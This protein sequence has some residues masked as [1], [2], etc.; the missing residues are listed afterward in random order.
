MLAELDE[1]SLGALRA[2]LIQEELGGPGRGGQGR[3]LPRLGATGKTGSGKSTLGNLL[4]GMSGLLRSTGFQDC[5]D[6]ADVL[7]FP[8]GLSYLDLPGVTGS[9]ALENGNRA[10]LGLPQRA[11]LERV[12]EVRV[13]EFTPAGVAGPPDG[14]LWPLDRLDGALPRPDLVLYVIAPHQNLNRDELPYLADLIAVYGVERVLFVLN[15][16]HRADGGPEATPQNFEDVHR[17]LDR[18][19]RTVGAALRP[20]RLVAMDC[21]TGEGLDRLLDTAQK[22]LDDDL[23]SEIVTRQQREV[24]DRYRTEVCRAVAAYVEQVRTLIPEADGAAAQELEGA[25]ARLLD[26]AVRLGAAAPPQ[27][28]P[29][30]LESFRGLAAAAGAALRREATEPIIEHREERITRTETVYEWIE[31]T[32]YGQPV[33]E[34]RRH[35]VDSPIGDFDDLVTAVVKWWRG[36]KLSA[37]RW[38][39]EQV[40]VGYGTIRRQVP[41]GTREVYDRTEHWDVTVGTRVTAV[42]YEPY[43]PVGPALLLAAW[44]AA[45]RGAQPSADL[46]AES[47]YGRALRAVTAGS[48]AEALAAFTRD[49]VPDVADPLWR[50]ATD[51]TMRQGTDINLPGAVPGGAR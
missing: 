10:A 9:D 21:R 41:A 7:H 6:G 31:E 37:E 45:L 47:V 38:E 16:F 18:V 26:Y 35:R 13:R 3:V 15:V 34:T 39:T 46:G 11:D 49:L 33:Y 28:A 20:D 44:S 17:R 24:P 5:T 23:L 40:C 2:R 48:R 50:S 42:Y 12:R 32:D 22:A 19:C 25:A 43:G 36:G 51:S 8:R 14:R 4:V 29:G 27:G 30:W 1:P